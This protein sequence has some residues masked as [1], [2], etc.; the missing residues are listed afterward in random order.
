MYSY[1][2]ILD[3]SI[4][5][6]IRFIS[7]PFLRDWETG[8]FEA[9]FWPTSSPLRFHFS[10]LPYVDRSCQPWPPTL[11]HLVKVFMMYQLYDI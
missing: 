2:S 9:L 7:V 5:I 8:A 4:H 1:I 10:K 6:H 3:H 11:R